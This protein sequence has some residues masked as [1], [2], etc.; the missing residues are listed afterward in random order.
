VAFGCGDDWNIPF[1]S[2][3]GSADLVSGKADMVAS[4]VL[5]LLDGHLARRIRQGR[6]RLDLFDVS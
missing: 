3:D 6:S 4:M 2:V 5:T 1:A